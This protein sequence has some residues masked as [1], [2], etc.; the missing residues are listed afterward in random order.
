MHV[1]YRDEG[2]PNVSSTEHCKIV[3]CM[4]MPRPVGRGSTA[5][6]NLSTVEIT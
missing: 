6:S 4:R 1:C 5:K 2:H 3:V